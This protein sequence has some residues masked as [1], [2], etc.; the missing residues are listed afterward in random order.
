MDLAHFSRVLRRF[1]LLVAVG[2][3]LGIVLAL[4][5]YYKISFDNG[6][7]V[8]TPRKAAVWQAP[9]TIFLASVQPVRTYSDPGRFIGLAPLYAQFANGDPVQQATRRHCPRLAGGYT[10]VP[11]A[12]NTFGVV[13]GL[14]MISMIGTATTPGAA[15]KAAR[16]ATETFITYMQDQQVA[17]RIPQSLRVRMT[18]IKAANEASLVVPRKKTLPIVVLVAVLF[19]TIALAFVLENAR[20][21]V[22]V[23]TTPEDVK[24]VRRTA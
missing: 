11:A 22:R 18:V 21:K 8:L 6:K 23:V 14:P 13:N 5:S 9:S 3:V 24:D 2:L 17:N 1:R 12:D 10:A 16:C 15:V 19:A 7:P 4:Y 20:P